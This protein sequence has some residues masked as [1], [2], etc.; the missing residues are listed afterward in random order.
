MAYKDGFVIEYTNQGGRINCYKCIFFNK[1]DKGCD[2][3]GIYVPD[4][5]RDKWKTCAFFELATDY[6]T[7]AMRQKA[8]RS[9]TLA[10]GKQLTKKRK[11]KKKADANKHQYVGSVPTVKGLHVGRK[12]SDSRNRI[13]YVKSLTTTEARVVFEDGSK[14]VYKIPEDF[15]DGRIRV[16]R[17]EEGTRGK[18]TARK[19]TCRQT[20]LKADGEM[21]IGSRVYSPKYGNGKIVG[22]EGMWVSVLF[23]KGSKRMRFNIESAMKDGRLSFR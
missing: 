1:S 3:T 17:F 13:G 2:K 6:D 15:S 22:A 14:G 16:L 8:E 18:E 23:K 19:N 11:A 10:Q 20:L 5:A 12:V 4:V 7:D 9:R 21:L